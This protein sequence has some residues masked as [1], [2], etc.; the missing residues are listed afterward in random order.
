[1]SSSTQQAVDSISSPKAKPGTSRTSS[2]LSPA[3]I[4]SLRREAKADD[5]QM[6]EILAKQAK[7]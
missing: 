4:E 5:L 6:Q 2:L 7:N 1:M 3:E